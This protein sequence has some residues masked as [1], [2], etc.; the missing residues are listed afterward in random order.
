MAAPACLV[1][2]D[3]Q[4]N[5]ARKESK[6]R[7]EEVN[8]EEYKERGKHGATWKEQLE[9]VKVKCRAGQTKRPRL[10]KASGNGSKRGNAEGVSKLQPSRKVRLRLAV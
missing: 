9:K 6:A 4:G 3:R 5:M 2:M 1:G 8:R 7:A 10:A